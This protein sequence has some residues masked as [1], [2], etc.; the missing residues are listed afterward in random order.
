MVFDA[1]G[2]SVSMRRA[3]TIARTEIGAAQNAALIIQ[4]DGSERRVRKTWAAIDDARTR[5][6]H[7]AADGQTI[8]PGEKFSVGGEFLAHPGDPNGSPGNIINCRCTM[9]LEPIE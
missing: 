2:G 5:P 8:D 3:R 7:A 1:L 4:A 6:A 9:L